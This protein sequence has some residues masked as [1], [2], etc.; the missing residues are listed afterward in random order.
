[1]NL[2]F[3]KEKKIYVGEIRK[4][5]CKTVN[6][7]LTLTIRQSP[8]QFFYTLLYENY[9]DLLLFA[10]HIA[11]YHQTHHKTVNVTLTKKQKE[12][13]YCQRK[14]KLYLGKVSV[15]S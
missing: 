11:T 9:Y 4:P 2:F 6:G 13:H 15:N 7:N 5:S 14:D 8:V 3:Q 1:M 10:I 12:K